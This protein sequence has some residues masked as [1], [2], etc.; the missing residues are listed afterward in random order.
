MAPKIRGSF[1]K[2]WDILFLMV[3]R[4]YIIKG[5]IHSSLD[6]LHIYLI[7]FSIAGSRLIY[8]MVLIDGI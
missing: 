8:G 7:N 6:P 2:S 4:K 3:C 1:P 5:H